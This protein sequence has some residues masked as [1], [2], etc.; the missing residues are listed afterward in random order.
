MSLRHVLGGG[1]TALVMLAAPAGTSSAQNA[2]EMSPQQFTRADTL[3]G[4]LRPE[5]TSYDV[6]WYGLDVRVD[7]ATRRVAGSNTIRFTAVERSQVMQ[8]DLFRA[9]E[10]RSAVLDGADSLRYLRE[11]NAVFFQLPRPLQPGTTHELVIRYDGEPKVAKNPPWD[12]GLIWTKDSTGN[13]WVA[14]ACEGTGASLW[15]PCK[16]HWADKPDSVQIGVTVPPGLEDV[17]NGRLRTVTTLPDG[18]RKYVWAVTYPINNYD[19]T[20]NVGKFAHFSDTYT[21]DETLTLDYYVLPGDLTKARRQFEQVKSMLGCFEK[22]FGPYPFARDGYK[23]VQSPH[24]GMEHQSAVAY[25][26]GFRNGYHGTASSS[27]GLKFDFIIIHES[28]HEWWGNSV[29]AKDPADM[30]IHEG[31]GAH[32]EA[33]YVECMFGTK[34]MLEYVNAKKNQVMN[35]R[36]VIG[37]YNVNNEGSGDMYPKGSLMLNTLRGVLDNDSLWHALIRGIAATYRYRTITT[38][39]IV[40]Y[41][42]RH[43][44]TDYTYFFD[45]YLRSPSIPRLEVVL[46]ARRDSLRCRYRWHADVKDFR[47]PVRV[48]AAPG[49]LA[50]IH[51]TTEW[52][53]AELG[54]MDP[55]DFRVDEDWFYIDTQIRIVYL[56]SE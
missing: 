29:T 50:F 12:G 31:F 22:D 21:G 18:W 47:M 40:A 30:W 7:P 26:N 34:A 56:A 15:W 13:P 32:A 37:T 48:T 36:P 54:G 25:G 9:M 42:N 20:I 41:V 35:R 4:M 19:V 11:F 5:R 52:Q 24:L 27:W 28:A 10:I 23:L 53:T 3:R 49:K 51:P 6:R 1:L 17:S 2:G 38:D 44:G 14:V 8:V 45:Q 43:T 16:D 33:M 39:T 46:L 55:K